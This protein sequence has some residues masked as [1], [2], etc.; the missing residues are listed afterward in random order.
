MNPLPYKDL[1]DLTLLELCVWREA[2]GESSDGKRAV[3]HTIRNRVYGA[4]KW[5]GHDW[6]S[7]ILHPYQ[8]SS[9]NANDPNADKWPDDTDSSFAECC[10]AALPVYLG[11]DTD[12]TQGATYYHDTSMGWPH[13]WGNAADYELTL[14]LGRLKFYKPIPQN[15]HE[16]VQAAATGDA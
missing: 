2:R 7:V 5:W 4:T 14:E 11:N 6:H 13:A 10:Q 8:F 12:L 9:F 16:A 15:T 1:S 3:A